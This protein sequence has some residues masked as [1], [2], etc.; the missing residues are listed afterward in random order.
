VESIAGRVAG[1][2]KPLLIPDC[3]HIPHKEATDRVV[4]EMAEFILTL[5]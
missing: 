3:A 5:L 1:P 4:K 2:A